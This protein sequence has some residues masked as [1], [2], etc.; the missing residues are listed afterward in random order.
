[1]LGDKSK[2]QRT[3]VVWFHLHAIPRIDRFIKTAADW[4]LPGAG[5]GGG[6]RFKGP[7]FLLRVSI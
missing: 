4:R 7:E 3:S 5:D 2:T 1:M 6:Y